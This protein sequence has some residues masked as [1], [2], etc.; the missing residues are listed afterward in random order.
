[1]TVVEETASPVRA[2]FHTLTVAAVEP[3]TSDSVA[4]TFDVPPELAEAYRFRPGQ[5]LTIRSDHGRAN[6]RRSYSIATPVGGPLRIG[7]KRLPGGAFS[8]W[9]CADLRPGMQLE[10]MTP[11][12]NFGTDISPDTARHHV[13][14]GAGSGITPL[15]SIVASVL[16]GE[17]RSTVTLLYGSRGSA[18]IMFGEELADLKDSYPSRFQLLH[19]LSREPQA[20]PLRAGRLDADKLDGVLGPLVPLDADAWYLCGPNDAVGTWAGVLEAR[21]VDP[22]R[23][24]R[25]I[26]HRG[27]PVSPAKVDSTHVDGPHSTVYFTLDGRS[28]EVEISPE[29]TVLDG[30]LRLRPDAPYACRGGVCGTCRATVTSGTA[31]MDA[32]FALEDDELERGFVL[33]CQAR[34]KGPELTVDYDR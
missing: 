5:H 16:A 7:V 10:V 34:P 21:G 26:F 28:G 30:V 32:N 9:A 3:L 20:S 33:T 14:L 2:A 24:H 4:V 6:A 1:M 8:T 19:F 25:E 29:E 22:A 23:V 15:L 11:K 31:A 12:G 18:Q 13:A 17:P 27:A